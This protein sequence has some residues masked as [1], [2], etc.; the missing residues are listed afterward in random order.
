[1]KDVVF[2]LHRVYPE[3]GADDLTLSTFERALSL[4]E[5]RFQIVPLDAL[6]NEKSPR[7]RAAITFDDGYA[8]NWVYAYPVLKKRGLKAHLFVS[9]GRI[10]EKG[11]RPNLSDYWEGKV[12]FKELYRPRSMG[13][14]HR[15][16]IEKG[17]S[18][19]FLSWEELEQ[20]KDVFTFGAHGVNHFSFPCKEEILDFYDGSNFHWT[21]L[22][23]GKPEIGFPLFPTK[24]ELA[25]RKFYPS[26]ELLELCL[27]YP[28]E[29]NW[30]EKL[31]LEI[32]KLP[33]LGSFESC[34]EAK[35][36]V[37]RELLSSKLEIERRLEVK[38]DTFAW[39]FG[40]Y[41]DWS[42]EIASQVYGKLFT[43]KKGL[44]TEDSDPY[45]LPRVSLGKDIFTVLG[46]LFTFSSDLG[47]SLYKTFK[48]DKVL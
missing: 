23:Y 11:V 24:S 22:L 9:T 32:K 4:I 18:E 25:V 33:S 5:K 2:F 21:L 16:F 6:F 36:R 46:R 47:F 34:E 13:Q 29:G 44:I 10:L 43:V 17:S 14:A 41:S 35:E 39:P 31:K 26:R 45:E 20:M 8:D 38:V 37:E 1:M 3:K 7:R 30:K 48:G 12:S 42:K 40:Q 15:E 27:S 19:E 28:K